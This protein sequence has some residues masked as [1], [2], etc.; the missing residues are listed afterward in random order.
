[1]IPTNPIAGMLG[2]A[3]ASPPVTRRL[4]IGGARFELHAARAPYACETLYRVDAGHGV[5]NPGFSLYLTDPGH[6][7]AAL[8]RYL[9]GRQGV[10]RA[11]AEAVVAIARKEVAP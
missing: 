5:S 11:E 9:A 2:V 1:M 7:A 10:K 3:A 6:H 8:G 4:T